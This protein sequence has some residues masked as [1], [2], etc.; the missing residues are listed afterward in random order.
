MKPRRS[1]AGVTGTDMA[2]VRLAEAAHLKRGWC[3][4]EGG[5]IAHAALALAQYLN[6]I[7]IDDG[8][9]LATD[10]FPLL[11]GGVVFVVHAA[12]SSLE[13]N[14]S[15]TARSA[16][17]YERMPDYTELEIAEAADDTCAERVLRAF[18]AQAHNAQP[19]APEECV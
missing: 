18:M 15:S 12:T 14:I 1:A 16:I 2:S 17:Y 3:Y 11:D 10:A 13:F 8:G 5:V 7:V 19:F 4:G 6:R 9:T